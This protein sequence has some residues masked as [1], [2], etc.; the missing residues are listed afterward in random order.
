MSATVVG[1]NGPPLTVRVRRVE[2]APVVA[3][4]LWVR[5]GARV[6]EIPGQA[7]VTGRLLSEGTVHR[8]FRQIAE[9]A[10][11]RGAILTSYGT[12][13][14]HGVSSDALATDW[15]QALDWAAELLL[16]P[17]FPADRCDW[18]TRQTAAE[19]ESLADQPEVVTAWAFLDQLYAPHPRRRPLQGTAESLRTITPAD[20][21]AFHRRALAGGVLVAAAGPFDPEAVERRIRESLAA[22]LAG[23]A[24][25]AGVPAF[26][27]PPAPAA[28]GPDH[29]VVA[30]RGEDQAHLFAGHLSIA[31]AHP[32]YEALEVLAVI[33][34][35]GA[36]LTGRIPTRIRE[37]EGLAYSTT[38]QTAAGAGV[39]VGRLVAYVGTSPGTVEQA[40][41]GVREE[42]AR[43]AADGVEDRE[44]EEA[45]AYLLGRE[46]FK[47]ETARQWAE[48]LVDAEDYGVPLDD[49][50][51][52][53]RR[54]EA[55]DRATVEAAARRHLRP[56]ELRVTVGMPEPEEP[57]EE[58]DEEDETEGEP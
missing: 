22:R 50:E 35:A 29:R 45:K 48:I 17:S 57:E 56:D 55:L 4:R 10:E 31:R 8:T 47:R 14:A 1:S 58:E 7:L 15:E 30:T 32:D 20:C 37:Q 23:I 21:A 12:F 42:I 41:R 43:L 54:L 34:G 9:D 46:P 5:A 19:L 18:I 6:E 28:G 25:I 2:G 33:L 49:P 13:E 52:R 51:D 11:E 26:P 38:A 39:D 53:R 16:E 3:F 40:E 36:G 44:L 24:G 27:A